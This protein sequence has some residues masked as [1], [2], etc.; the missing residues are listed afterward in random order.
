M[1]M[2]SVALVPRIYTPV[3]LVNSYVSSVEHAL[4]R[5]EYRSW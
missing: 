2:L 1:M 4:R 5:S 3:V